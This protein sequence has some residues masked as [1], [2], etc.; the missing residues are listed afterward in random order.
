MA[1]ILVVDDEAAIVRF[2]KAFLEKRGYTV[3]T[4]L[5]GSEAIEKLR[6]DKPDVMLLDIRLGDKNGLE[7]LKEAKSLAP[8]VAVVMITAVSD[9]EIG[10]QIQRGLDILEGNPV[11]DRVYSGLP[12]LHYKGPEKCKKV[13]AIRDAS[14]KVV[15]GNVNV[16][17]IW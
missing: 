11:P 1:K 4:A 16:H 7:V 13:T 14:G 2:L 15:G 10:K 8:D 9:E 17:Q 6:Q 3:A 12:L 5:D